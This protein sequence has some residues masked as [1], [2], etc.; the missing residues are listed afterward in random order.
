MEGL[1]VCMQAV[2]ALTAIGVGITALLL[3]AAR[4]LCRYQRCHVRING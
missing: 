1:K 4:F 3:L 2:A